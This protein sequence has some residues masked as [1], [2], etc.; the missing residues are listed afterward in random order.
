VA[1]PLPLFAQAG[2]TARLQGAILDP[3]GNLVAGAKLTIRNDATGAVEKTITDREGRYIFSSLQPG[4]FAVTVAAPGFAPLTQPGI[5]LRVSQQ[6]ALD[7]T[8]TVAQNAT[9]VDVRDANVLLASANGELGQEITGRYITEIPLADRQIEKL[10]YLAPGVTESQGFDADQTNENY[11]SNGQRNSSAEIRL[12]GSL[13]SVPEAGEGA[14]FWS[15]YQ[16]SI[17]IVDQFQVQTNGFSAE[18]GSNGGT[19]LNYF[20]VAAFSDP[21]DQVDGNEPRFNNALRGDSIRDIDASLFKNFTFRERFKLQ[22]RAEFFN[23]FNTVRFDDPNTSF[24]NSSFGVISSQA[25]N[26]RQAQMG[27]RLVF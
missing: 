12:D 15:H 4:A 3:S 11:S 13:L 8:L 6:S 18:Y 25:N 20:N 24:G 17:E 16:P 10:T 5:V 27:A 19:A 9:S 23:F 22:I 21:G 14:M 7:L 26:P 2:F 1:A